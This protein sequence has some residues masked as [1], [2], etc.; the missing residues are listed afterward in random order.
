MTQVVGI[1]PWEEFAKRFESPIFQRGFLCLA[2]NGDQFVG[3]AWVIRFSESYY[4]EFTGVHPDFRGRGI[5]RSMKSRC[6]EWL[7]EQGVSSIRTNNDS[8]NA[9]MITVNERL[10]YTAE[11]GWFLYEADL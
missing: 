9:P 3:L 11:P 2:K 10:G 4:N 1:I 6:I 7:R 5:A 8:R